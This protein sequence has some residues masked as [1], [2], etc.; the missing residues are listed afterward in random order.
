MQMLVM[1]RADVPGRGTVFIKENLILLS[2]GIVTPLGKSEHWLVRYE[3]IWIKAKTIHNAMA[4]V[5]YCTDMPYARCETAEEFHERSKIA[6][7]TCSISQDHLDVLSE[8]GIKYSVKEEHTEFL[9]GFVKY[10][11]S[12]GSSPMGR[13]AKTDKGKLATKSWR[14]SEKGK[15]YAEGRRERRNLF[16][17]AEKWIRLHPNKSF[18]DFLKEVQNVA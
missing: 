12:P 3:D 17:D 7:E 5:R 8:E 6:S 10:L 9:F 15:T 4:F 1:Q 14:T 13:Y 11:E 16:R 18:E 2:K